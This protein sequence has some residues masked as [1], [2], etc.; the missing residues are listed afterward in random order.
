MVLPWFSSNYSLCHVYPFLFVVSPG[1]PSLSKVEVLERD[2]L[3]NLSIVQVCQTSK[4]INKHAFIFH[5]LY[6]K[7]YPLHKFSKKKRKN[8]NFQNR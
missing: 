8:I 3:K 5:L 6:P 1:K 4:E 2:M 7:P